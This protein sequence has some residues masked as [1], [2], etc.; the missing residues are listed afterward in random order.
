MS[1]LFLF[2]FLLILPIVSFSQVIPEKKILNNNPVNDTTR[3]ISNRVN[4]IQNAEATIEQ[5]LI[6]NYKKDTTYVDTTLSIKKEYKYNY[7]RKDNFNLIQFANTGQTYNTL[8]F[9]NSSNKTLPLFAARARHFNYM[10]IEDTYYYKVPTPLTEL[11]FKTVFE[12]GQALD[13]FFTVNTSQ[14]FNFS[15]AYKGLRSLGN[16]QNALTS[17]GNFRIT[18]NYSTKN[19]RYFMR[20]HIVTQDLLN[21]ENG[22]LS[23]DDVI[24]FI[25]GDEEITDRSL[26]DPNFEN[27]ENILR[28]KRFHLEHQYNIIS[29]RDSVSYSE[30]SLHNTVSF[31]DKYYQYEQTAASNS[32]FGD[33]FNSL[34][35]D[36]VTL[37]YFYSDISILLKNNLLGDLRLGLNYNNINYGYNSLVTINNQIIPNRIKTDFFGFSSSY[38]KVLGKLALQGNLGLNISD[39]IKGNFIDGKLNYALSDNINLFGGININSRLPN[40][41]Q[42]LY[43]SSYNNYNWNN[44]DNFNYIQSQQLSFGV[45]SEKY[46]NVNLDI[47]N[48][49]NYTYFNLEDTVNNIKVVKPKQ[50][51]ESI[52]YFRIK[53]QKEFR[54]GNFRL[55]NTIMYQNVNSSESVLNVPDFITRNTLY[56]TDEVFKK[57]LKF[58]AGIIFNYFSEYNANA[59]DPLLAEFYTQN[60]TQI[61]GFPRLDFFINAKVRQTRIFIK[62]EHF[63]SSFTGYNYFSAP[64]HPYRDFT[65]RFGLVW[66][67]F[68]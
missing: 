50:F 1:R 31:E 57:A 65:V 30:L 20:G 33:S 13:A 24:R 39:E 55:D 3:V 26:F 14:Q 8:S 67:F 40:Y 51:D 60:Q 52:Q 6:V 17:T 68:L 63:N 53:L 44:Q 34:I 29:K 32:F 43:Q 36:R 2:F 45:R 7:L 46:V 11:F 59:Y 28:G 4:T 22:G 64:N 5:Y 58:Q 48:I 61:G 18:T 21:Q 35:R 41:N 25:D 27:A 38:H 62:A 49:D 47:S 54:L 10:E 42:L 15:I 16:Y 12:Q 23:D 9:D 19:K 37:E 66:N 56:Y